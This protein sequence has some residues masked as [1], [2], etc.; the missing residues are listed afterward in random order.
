MGVGQAVTA[1]LAI[2]IGCRRGCPAEAIAALVKQARAKLGRPGD[3]GLF[4]IADKRD[5]PGLAEAARRLGLD[6]AFLP[7]EALAAAMAGVVTPS[8]GAEARFGVA[9]VSE[10]AALAG[11]GPGARLLLARLAAGGAT[12]AIA[13]GGEEPA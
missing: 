2:G 5:E 1:R 12:C 4:T 7:R 13:C 6:L 3:A 8:A 9:S 10:A 11:A